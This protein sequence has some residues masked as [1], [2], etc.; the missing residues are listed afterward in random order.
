MN[1]ESLKLGEFLV[2]KR[3]YDLS[4]SEREAGIVPIVSSSGV[5]GWHNTVKIQGPGVVTGRYGTLGKVFFMKEDYWPLNTTL[6]VQDFKGNHPQFIAYFLKNLLKGVTSSK[7]AVP[8]L[9]RNDLHA[10]LVRTTL[11]LDI[12]Q[13]IASI[14]SAYDD[15][16]E[17]N[18]RR[19]HLLEQSAQMLYKE[20]FVRLRFPGHEQVEVIDGVPGGWENTSIS[21]VCETIGGGTPSTKV[22]EYWEGEIVWVVPSDITGNDSLVLL[23]SERKITE[24]GLRKSSAKLLP[25]NTILM[26]SRASVG[27]FAL[28][29]LEVCTNQG[30]INIIPHENYFRMYLL[31]NLMSRVNE[32]RS[33]AKGTTFAEI[34][35]TRFRDM[36]ITK[37]PKVIV[38]QFGNHIDSIIQQIWCLKKS[39]LQLTKARDLLLPRLMNG[40][41]TV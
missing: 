27:F 16:I 9:N 39:N 25:A 19:I 37:P 32:I 8:G 26:T 36:S 15:L 33:N 23:D 40:E 34:S 41:L 1:W 3:G 6:Y 14:L 11:N 17:N 7:A 18:R 20:W 13:K 5:T 22:P 31:F 12:Q 4:K 30:F 29:D 10:R 2:L 24:A 38:V 21:S 28:V 35:K